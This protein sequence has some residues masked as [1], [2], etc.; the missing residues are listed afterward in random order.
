MIPIALGKVS[1]MFLIRAAFWLTLV[2]AFIPV[3][4]SD[5]PVGQRSISTMETVSLAQS[6]FADL[7]TFCARN[8]ETCETGGVLISQM[9][10]KA[11][12][13]AKLAYTWLDG[14][15]GTSSEIARSQADKAEQPVDPVSTSSISAN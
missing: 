4:Q 7:S 2:I 10:M 9:G 6:V 1:I 8:A 3:K 13:G 11:R 12:E 15:Y 5:L 14:R